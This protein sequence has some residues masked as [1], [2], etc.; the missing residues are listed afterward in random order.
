MKR[1]EILHSWN[2]EDPGILYI[3]VSFRGRDG[4]KRSGFALPSMGGT[5]FWGP[6]EADS[7][8]VDKTTIATWIDRAVTGSR[9]VLGWLHQDQDR[10]DLWMKPLAYLYLSQVPTPKEHV[11]RIRT[12]PIQTVLSV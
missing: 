8:P 9:H 3:T 6:K 11:S 4:T 2:P 12:K 5:V 1:A 7:S 10:I